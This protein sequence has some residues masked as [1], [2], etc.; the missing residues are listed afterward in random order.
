MLRILNTIFLY[1]IHTPGC[2]KK[3]ISTLY[4]SKFSESVITQ[5]V[6]Y[7][8]HSFIYNYYNNK[9]NFLNFP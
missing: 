4:K 8:Q 9:I 5:Y 3:Q 1:K 6:Q 7:K 2:I